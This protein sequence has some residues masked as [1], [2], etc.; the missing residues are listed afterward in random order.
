MRGRCQDIRQHDNEPANAVGAV[1]DWLAA[2][3]SKSARP[4]PGATAIMRHYQEFRPSRHAAR[5]RPRTGG[6]G[7][8]R[9]SQSDGAISRNA[10]GPCRITG[11]QQRA[12]REHILIGG[13]D[14]WTPAPPCRDLAGHFPNEITF[15]AYPG[16]YHDLNAPN[17][18]V[19][20]RIGAATAVGGKVHVGTNEP[21]FEDALAR[22]PK[23]LEEPR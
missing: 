8:L 11:H 19:K 3:R 7:I 1:R 13:D 4:L 18:A 15:V 17:G 21:A 20:V 5:R 9:S 22:L 12:R 10:R 16:V 23:W 2:S 6:V 14:G